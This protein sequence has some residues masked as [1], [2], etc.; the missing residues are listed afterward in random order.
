MIIIVA[1]LSEITFIHG[2][3]VGGHRSDEYMDLQCTAKCRQVLS[4]SI[5]RV[6]KNELHGSMRMDLL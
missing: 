1:V 4:E 2:I 5:Q 6:P 3:L